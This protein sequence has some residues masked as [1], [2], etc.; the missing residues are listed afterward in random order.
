M[1]ITN[2]VPD[3][4]WHSVWIA[5]VL[6]FS[7]IGFMQVATR[8]SNPTLLRSRVAGQKPMISINVKLLNFIKLPS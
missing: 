3:N 8:Y 1:I 6:A 7:T 2:L 5:A 4:G